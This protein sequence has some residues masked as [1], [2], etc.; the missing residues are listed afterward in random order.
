MKSRFNTARKFL[1]FWCLFVGL[2]AVLGSS[3]MLIKTDGS[4]MQMQPM[5]KYF[6][7]LP[8]PDVLFKDFLFPGIAL[9]IVNGI[10]N[11]V[12]A[13]LLFKKKKAGVVL[14]TIFGI[15]LMLWIT[16]QFIIFPANILSILYFIF[17]ALQF[18]TGVIT[19]VF[20]AQEQFK[21]DASEY[22]NIG[23]D[24]TRLVVFFSR[25]G[26][27]R[28]KALEEA[29]RTGAEIYEVKST[30]N[31][32]GTLGFWWCGRYGMH[33][34]EMPIEEIEIDLS[35]YEHVTICSP[36]WVFNLCAPMRSFCKKAE[37]KIRE[38]DYI[39]VH[40]QKSDYMNAVNE[41]NTLLKIK[42][43]KVATICC[44]RGRYLKEKNYE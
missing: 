24:K 19:L 39:L 17:G 6:E 7:V 26:Y 22:S 32:A 43:T 30:E 25:M 2:G 36:I 42:N 29:N 31:T 10:T 13:A 4:I 16:I 40:H 33:K 11:L 23:S 12:A 9:L 28:K 14:G 37:G 44:R 35:S 34:W 5:L 8:F 1:I 15:T 27:V 20:Y 38:A 21:A 3:C 41:M 18:L